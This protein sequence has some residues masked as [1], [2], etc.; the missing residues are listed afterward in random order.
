MLASVSFI[1]FIQMNCRTAHV[2][3]RLFVRSA[4][5]HG[6]HKRKSAARI[7]PRKGGVCRK[8]H[9]PFHLSPGALPRDG[10]KPLTKLFKNTLGIDAEKAFLTRKRDPERCLRCHWIFF[11]EKAVDMP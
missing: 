5:V 8:T 11:A 7:V 3:L 2:T 1:F 10:C 4:C 6:P 9:A